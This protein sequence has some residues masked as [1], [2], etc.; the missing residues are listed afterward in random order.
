M[1]LHLDPDHWLVIASRQ[2]RGLAPKGFIKVDLRDKH[3][4]RD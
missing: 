3:Q 1:I 2:H 4:V